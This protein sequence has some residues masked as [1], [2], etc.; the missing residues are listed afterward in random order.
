MDG[1]VGWF[2]EERG[3]LFRLVH[4]L[5]QILLEIQGLSFCRIPTLFGSG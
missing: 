3:S 5:V 2:V 4:G 1:Q